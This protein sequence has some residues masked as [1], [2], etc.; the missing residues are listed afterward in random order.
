LTEMIDADAISP[1]VGE[2]GG[3]PEGGEK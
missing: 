3:S 1:L 2:M